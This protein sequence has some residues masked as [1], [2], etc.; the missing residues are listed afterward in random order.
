MLTILAFLKTVVS[1]ASFIGAGAA[2]ALVGQ[3]VGRWFSPLVGIVCGAA[4]VASMA[5]LVWSTDNTKLK[6][7]NAAL[8]A[9]QVELVR[10]HAALRET[11]G[12]LSKA[13][14]DNEQTMASLRKKLDAM[15]DKPE[16]IIPKDITD[17]LNKIR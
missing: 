7:Q 9:K 1:L 3:V 14:Q 5:V 17:E 4:I 10:T 12:E 8:R 11:L 6:A 15:P 13:A 16:C 2:A